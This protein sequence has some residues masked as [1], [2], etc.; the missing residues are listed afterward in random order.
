MDHATIGEWIAAARASRQW[1]Q[2]RLG[3]E[4]GVGKANV[5]HWETGKHEP[6]LAQLLRIRDLTGYPL[7]DFGPSMSWPLPK[8]PRE[9]ITSLQ[10]EQLEALQIAIIAALAALAPV[11]IADKRDAA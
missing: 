1:N 2:T 4:I 10:P 8:V 9:R 3:D 7:R 5:S 6:S 11:A